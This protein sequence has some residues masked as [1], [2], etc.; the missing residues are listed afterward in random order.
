MGLVE[1]GD[2]ASGAAGPCERR[3]ASRVAARSAGRAER[4]IAGWLSTRDP[5]WGM[6][7]HARRGRASSGVQASHHRGER[8]RRAPG[9]AVTELREAL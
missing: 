5:L 3:M 4:V 7:G 2:G 1:L 8:G 9:A 6:G